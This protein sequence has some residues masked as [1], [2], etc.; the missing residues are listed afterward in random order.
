MAKMDM[1]NNVFTDG[2]LSNQIYANGMGQDGTII[3]IQGYESVTI[4]VMAGVLAMPAN[5]DGDYDIFLLEA[6]ENPASPGTPGAFTPVDQTYI[7]GTHFPSDTN[8]KILEIDGTN[9]N[10]RDS[11]YIFGYIGSKRFIR[12]QFDVAN[13][14]NGMPLCAIAVLGNPHSAPVS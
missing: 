3:D 14:M 8:G 9:A 2:A 4:N 10:E 13:V 11:V 5:T 1:Y 7:Q 12:L 6:D